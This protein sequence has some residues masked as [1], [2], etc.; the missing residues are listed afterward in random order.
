IVVGKLSEQK[1]PNFGYDAQKD[2]YC[3]LVKAGI[4]DPVKVVRHALQ[5]SASVAGLLIT[6]EATI[7]ELPKKEDN[8]GGHGGHGGGMD[9]MM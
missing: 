4:I 6:T 7:A 9:G 5:D 1:D 3:D 8:H 2:Q